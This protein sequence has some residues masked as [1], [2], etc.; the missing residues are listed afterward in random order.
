MKK[1]YLIL[2]P[3][4]I[5]FIISFIYLPNSLKY[6]ELLFQIIGILLCIF[7]SNVRFNKII[8]YS[9]IYYIIS[10]ILL[11]LVLILNKYTNGS[12]AWIDLKI[13]SIQPSEIIKISLILLTYKY[14]DKL[15]IYSLSLIYIIPLAL[16]YLE[17]DTGGVLINLIIYIYFLF[18]KLNKNQ[19]IRLF[20]ILFIFISI[21][22]SIYYFNKDIIFK[23][24]S[25]Y[26]LDRLLTF[27]N[28]DNL[29]TNNAL[30]S[31]AVSNT[32]YYP[33]MYNDFFISY[34]LSNNIYLLF[35]INICIILILIYLNKKN[36]I[37]S[38]IVFY[39]ILFQ[40]FYNI[41]MNL[42]LVPVI[43]IP[44]LFISYGGSHLITYLILIG[45]IISNSKD[46][47]NMA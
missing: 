37:I 32:L 43:G 16:I 2:I 34:I 44:C 30:I 36:T 13:I 8:K 41:L 7:I 47:Y 5:L 35:V 6:K 33:E 15:N 11:I 14:F 20:I 23:I 31:I 1:K 42:K 3:I 9:F 25:P 24:I 46:N 22:F 40:C 39:L 38:N 29:Q 17:P 27:I 28:G 18:K 45:I 12:R 26:R 10:I 21:L 4:I 19:I